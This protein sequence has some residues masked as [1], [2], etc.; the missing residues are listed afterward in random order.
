[1]ARKG[2]PIYKRGDAW[3]LDFTH[4]GKRHVVRLG[5]KIA[6]AAAK[7]IAVAKRAAILKGE[8]GIAKRRKD[9]SFSDATEEFLKWA[10]ANKREGTY[11]RYKSCVTRLKGFFGDRKLG[12]IHPFLIE[13]YKQ[14][15]L[16]E[17]AKVAV[18]RE[19][20]RL[21]TLYNLCIKWK[22]YEGDNP[23][24]RFQMVPESRGRFLSNEEEKSLLA[25]CSE[26]LRSVVVLA[27]HT[28][29][30]AH[31]EGLSLT[32]QNVDFGR[33]T[34]TVEDHFAKN[35]ETRTVPLNSI[36]LATLKELEGRVPGPWVFM[37]N[38]G[39]K[40]R[41]DKHWEQYKSFRTAFESACRHDKLS[42]VTPHVLRHSFA[43]RLVMQGV[44]LRTVQELGGWKSLNMVQRYAHLS[45][46]H[47]RQAVEL[48]VKNSTSLIT[49]PHVTT[50]NKKDSNSNYISKMGR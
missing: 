24:R 44:D 8:V 25:K 40:S 43:S 50:A 34:I 42:G 28:G 30:R 39:S 18:N 6:F 37:T 27:I 35:A 3:R 29:E 17:G 23:A 20:S 5:R 26:P 48:L 45:Q 11:V 19:L 22:K 38:K 15:R 7:D 2:D 14:N 31:S 41:G 46:D 47:K 16:S 36:A 13:K 49:P 9:I 21:R 33:R 32:W 4:E 10:K 12:D 1:M